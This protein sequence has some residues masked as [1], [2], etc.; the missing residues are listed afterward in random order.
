MDITNQENMMYGILSCVSSEDT[1]IIFKGGLI[2]KLILEENGYYIGGR[3]TKDIDA[4]WTG[5]P[6]S[7]QNIVDTLNVS[8][9]K[10][11]GQLKAELYREYDLSTGR[12]AGINLVDANGQT[13]VSIDMDIKPL[14]QNTTYYFGDTSIKGVLVDEIIADKISSVSSEAV[15]KYRCKD[16]VDLYA[17]AHCT[18]ISTDSISE[19]CE[20]NKRIIG[21]FNG[22]INHKSEM[23]HAYN[24]LRN[25]KNKPDFEDVYD[26]L[27]T[28]LQPYIAHDTSSKKWNPSSNCW[29]DGKE[30]IINKEERINE[31]IG[32]ETELVYDMIES[33]SYELREGKDGTFSIYDTVNN[34]TVEEGIENVSFVVDY[35]VGDNNLDSLEQ[36]AHHQGI[37]NIPQT[38][39][40]WRNAVTRPDLQ[41]FIE[42]HKGEVAE[43]LLAADPDRMNEKVDLKELA[44]MF[45]EPSKEIE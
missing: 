26:Y 8:L 38:G 10:L 5:T 31:L 6:P 27:N 22:F 20:R 25:I 42:G 13:V 11:D 9:E 39:D 15:Y 33:N 19:V 2:T 35:C 30:T 4:N 45:K 21:D 37:S 14:S 16:I 28:F 36:E 34:E 7:M 41:D 40:E 1:P 29:S 23:E 32:N 12:S 24:R 44:D 18:E 3:Q 17:L 43:V